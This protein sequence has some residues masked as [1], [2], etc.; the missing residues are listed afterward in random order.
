MKFVVPISQ[1]GCIAVPDTSQPVRVLLADNGPDVAHTVGEVAALATMQARGE[2]EGFSVVRF[3]ERARSAPSEH[4]YLRDLKEDLERERP[5]VVIVRKLAGLPFPPRR[6]IQLFR[7]Y[8][9]R[10]IY[11]DLD[12]WG[13][14]RKPLPQQVVR[15]LSAFDAAVTCAYG[16]QAM[17]LRAAVRGPVLVRPHGVSI[18]RF[19]DDGN[20]SQP[21][22]LGSIVMLGNRIRS[23]VPGRSIPGSRQR[24]RL[25]ERLEDEFGDSFVVYGSG[26]GTGQS[27]KGP[28][29]FGSSVRLMAAADV[30]VGF[31]HFPLK[32]GYFSDRLPIALFAGRPHVTNWQPGYGSLLGDAQGLVLV[33]GGPA[34]IVGTVKR[35]LDLSPQARAASGVAGRA[36]AIEHLSVEN[37]YRD[38]VRFSMGLRVS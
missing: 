11:E 2:L 1:S 10:L 14:L 22:K 20:R 38:V 32:P 30:T 13:I 28:T 24:R 6:T 29:E 23:K 19:G 33:K 35:L 8:A 31:D 5:H 7:R 37:L 18:Q 36:Y 4:T 3:I 16:W 26:W 27:R 17:L 15:N 21:V 25:V 12:A 34:R 9:S